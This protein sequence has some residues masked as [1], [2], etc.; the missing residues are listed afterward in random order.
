MTGELEY[1]GL[2]RKKN[3]GMAVRRIQEWLCLHGLNIAVDES[4]GPA[5]EAA[6]QAFQ[7]KKKL[8]P[9]GTLTRPTF[10]ELV[11]PMTKALAPLRR[12]PARIG[13][14]VVHHAKAHLA[15]HPREVGGQNRGPWVRLY[16][17]GHEGEAWPW[18]AGFV[19]FIVEQASATIGIAMP[20]AKTFS[21]DIL[22]SEGQ[23]A[24]EFV[25]EAEARADTSLLKP[26]TVFLSR[27]TRRDWTHT[28]LVTRVDAKDVFSTIEG[29]T[30]DEGSR[31]GYEVCARVRGFGNKDF[32]TLV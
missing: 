31:E 6:L 25:S 12:R 5:T 3:R 13:T 19:S 7:R 28:G 2:I 1:P 18:C 22:A 29:N 20:F 27:R 21:C 4:F 23:M 16:M 15:Q 24:G 32:V 10:A 11:E 30:N 9:T 14:A 26:G 8:A 17:D